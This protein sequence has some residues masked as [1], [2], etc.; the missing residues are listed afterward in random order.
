MIA[1]VKQL[2]YFMGRVYAVF[3]KKLPPSELTL[4]RPEG[5]PEHPGCNLPKVSL[6]ISLSMLHHIPYNSYFVYT[7]IYSRS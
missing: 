6:F 4:G 5:L 3:M 1:A 7:E 2:Y